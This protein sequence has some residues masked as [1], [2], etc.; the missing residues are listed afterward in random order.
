MRWRGTARA[1]TRAHDSGGL[2]L[3]LAVATAACS[4]LVAL[5]RDLSG[6]SLRVVRRD[7]DLFEPLADELVEVVLGMLDSKSLG[8]TACCNRQ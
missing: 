1:A 8:S 3:L 6:R 7:G 5:M 2:V 4:L